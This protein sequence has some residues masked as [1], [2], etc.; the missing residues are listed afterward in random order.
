MPKADLKGQQVLPGTQQK[1]DKTLH[2]KAQKYAE[3]RDARM[4]LNREEKE[5]KDDLIAYM[6][7]KKVEHYEVGNI[8]IDLTQSDDIKVRVIEDKDEG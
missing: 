5:L 8:K 6:R 1:R 3:V 4:N 7:S 2:A